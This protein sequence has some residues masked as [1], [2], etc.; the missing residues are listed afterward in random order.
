MDDLIA[1]YYFR[2]RDGVTADFAAQAISE[3]QTTGTWTNLST[4][5]D[6]TAYVHADD[7]EVMDI[8]SLG[9]GGYV[10]RIRYPYEI[11]E[12]GNIPQYLSVIAGNLFGLGKL[13]AVRLLDID[14]PDAFRTVHPGPKFGI[15]GVR[16]IVGT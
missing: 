5:N 6:H 2:P 4:V 8:V 14:L 9:D 15:E 3:E 10:T 11:F 7:G 12:P 16:K 13:E 1:T